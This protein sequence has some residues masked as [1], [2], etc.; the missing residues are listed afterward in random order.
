MSKFDSTPDPIRDGNVWIFADGTRLPVISGGDGPEPEPDD[1]GDE[2][3]GADDQADAEVVDLTLVETEVPDDLSGLS[4]DELEGI[5]AALLD[6]LDRCDEG[7]EP[8]LAHAEAVYNQAVRVRE[9]KTAKEQEQAEAA[10]RLAQMRADLR[11]EADEDADADAA[12]DEADQAADEVADADAAAD[13]TA[14]AEPEPVPASAKRQLGK[15]VTPTAPGPRGASASATARRATRPAVRQ[16]PATTL[17]ITAAGDVSGHSAGAPIT[18]RGIAMA[19]H[20]KARNLKK[21]G[22][23]GEV[24]VATIERNIPRSFTV[25]EGMSPEEQEATILRALGRN[26]DGQAPQTAEALVAAGG[27]CAPPQIEYG[28]FR[29]DSADGTLDLP[30]VGIERGGIMI[31]DFLSLASANPAYWSWS[32]A[33]DAA[34]VATVTNKALTSNVATLTTGAAHGFAVGQTVKVAIGDP[35]FDGTFVIASVP[36]S[37][38]FTYAKTNANVTSAAATGTATLQKGC[39]KIPCPGFTE[40]T[41]GADGFCIT[42][43]NLSNRAWPE[44]T[45]AFVG[46]TVNG[47]LHR[48]SGLAVAAMQAAMTD[49]TMTATSPATDA[50]GEVI[51]ALTLAAEDMR[52]EFK[53][54]DGQA[55]EAVF[56]RYA[57]KAMRSALAKRKGVESWR[58]SVQDVVNAIAVIGVRAQFVEALQPMFSGSAKQ[59]WPT[60][61]NVL[62]YPAGAWFRGTGGEINLGVMRDAE[63]IKVNDYTAAWTEEFWLLGRR[64]PAGRELIITTPNTGVTGGP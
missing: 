40:Y 17:T 34:T 48:M 63:Q 60:T 19:M 46:L 24:P 16:A 20:D 14:D 37:T 23:S 43:G 5:E 41:L 55:F 62:L 44:L 59:A 64:G 3:E 57:A 25:T 61:M 52:S 4:L 7:D 11:G 21:D 10:D 13:D 31:P 38:T 33:N 36:T 32:E 49:V 30:E 22:S 27:W 53:M 35:V 2:G 8:D 18:P 47:H 54:S 56:P 1:E 39:L 6:E 12:A 28:I 51:S 29:I 50:F 26:N 58:V 45:T 15:R 42:H 9:Q